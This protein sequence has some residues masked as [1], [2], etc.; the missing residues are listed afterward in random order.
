M[1]QQGGCVLDPRT[2]PQCGLEDRAAWRHLDGCDPTGVQHDEPVAMLAAKHPAV[3]GQ[4]R[5][6]EP[7]DSSSST[8]SGST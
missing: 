1:A 7:V 3:V 2:L 8:G 5:Y 6:D 4:R